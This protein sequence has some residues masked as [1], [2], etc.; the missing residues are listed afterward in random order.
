[1]RAMCAAVLALEAI[2]LGLSTP[3]MIAVVDVDR[4]PALAGG[5]GLAALAVIAAALLRFEWAYWLGHL[6][7]V[8]AI[9]LGVVVTVMFVLGAIFAALWVA[10]ILLGRRVE[11]AK[12]AR[13][14]AA[15]SAGAR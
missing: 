11:Q 2:V 1:M 12:A 4:G 8:G 9:A 5:L 7:Q 6:V 10:A 15:Q 3:V 14:A 13:A